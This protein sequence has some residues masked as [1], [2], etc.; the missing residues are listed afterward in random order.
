[1]KARFPLPRLRGRGGVGA[2]ARASSDSTAFILSSWITPTTWLRNSAKCTLPTMSNVRGRG[3]MC[4]LDLPSSVDRDTAVRL[5]REQRVIVL[6]CGER[7]IR[8]R[9]ALDVTEQE[10]GF[11]LAALDRALASLHNLPVADN[12]R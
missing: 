6:P 4:A 9:P 7:T 10:L 8:F 1:M 5:L 3:L 2:Q 11:G 12:P